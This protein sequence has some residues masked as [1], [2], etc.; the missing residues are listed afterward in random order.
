MVKLK[1]IDILIAGTTDRAV[2]EK[3][4]LYVKYVDAKTQNKFVLLWS[5]GDGQIFPNAGTN[6]SIFL[7]LEL[8]WIQ[9]KTLISPHKSRKNMVGYYL[10]SASVIAWNWH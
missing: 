9:A 5:D 3:E 4:V 7:P 8:P 1:S 2:T 10:Y 6:R